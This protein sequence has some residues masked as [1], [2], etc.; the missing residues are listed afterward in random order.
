MSSEAVLLSTAVPVFCSTSNK[1]R[2]VRYLRDHHLKE[3]LCE[4]RSKLIRSGLA[5]VIPIEVLKLMTAD[6]LSLRLCGIPQINLS[7]LKVGN[8]LK[9]HQTAINCFIF[10]SQLHT[11]YQRGISEQDNHVKYFWKAL[12]SFSQVGCMCLCG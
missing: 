2:F 6:D 1:E 5:T 4:T 11:I 12:H 10:L 7:F 9:S 8:R 3:L